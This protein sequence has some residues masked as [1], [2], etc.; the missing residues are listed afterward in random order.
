[1][2]VTGT[3]GIG[4]TSW[5]IYLLWKLAN[6]GKTVLLDL[7]HQLYLFSRQAFDFFGAATNL[8]LSCLQFCE[9]SLCGSFTHIFTHKF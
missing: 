5:I 6:A 4:K 7:G 1:M 2:L 8:L 9:L 3:P